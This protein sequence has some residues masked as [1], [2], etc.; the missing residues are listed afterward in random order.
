M[1]SLTVPKLSGGVNAS[2]DPTMIEDNELASAQNVRWKNGTLIKRQAVRAVGTTPFNEIQGDPQLSL[3]GTADSVLS[4][5]MDIGG[6]LCTLVHSGVRY[7]DSLTWESVQVISLGGEVKATYRVMDR[8]VQNAV[9]VPCDPTTYGCPFLM[10]RGCAVFKP[11]E[12]TGTMVAVPDEELYAPLVMIN[13]KSAVNAVAEDASAMANGVMYEGFNLLTRRYRARF[14]TQ[15]GSGCEVFKMPTPLASGTTVSVDIVTSQGELFLQGKVGETVANGS[16]QLCVQPDGAVQMYPC[17]PASLVSDNLTVTATA[18]HTTVSQMEGGAT[19]GVWFGGTQNKLGGTRLFL[20][21]F[22]GEKAKVMWSDVNNPLYFPENNYMFVGDLSQKVTALEKQGDMLVIF[23]EREVYY[24]TY[25]QGEIDADSVANGTNVDVT[26]SQAHF[27][28][29]QLSPYIGCDAPASLAVCRDRLVWICTDGRVY[30]LIEGSPYSERNVREIG[31]KIYPLMSS[32]DKVLLK[33][34]SAMDYDGCYTVLIG[35]TAYSFDYGDSGF[36]A[37]TSYYTA[38]KAAENIAWY[39]HR[40]EVFASYETLRLVS[41]GAH[42]AILISTQTRLQYFTHIRMLYRFEDAEQDSHAAVTLSA[43]LAAL[44]TVITD[45]MITTR[46]TTKTYDFGDISCFKRIVSLFLSADAEELT[47]RFTADGREAVAVHRLCA[48]G[49]GGQLLLPCVKRCRT[50][51][52]TITSE[53]AFGLR[54]MRVQYTTFGT[55]R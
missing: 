51:S 26:V 22:A 49:R 7:G 36:A 3:T 32:H 11:D 46:F 39:V 29:T 38:E 18:A 55:V 2:V 6:E 31:Q 35:N 52:M 45:A 4:H 13:G 8:H 33:N 25:V 48:D 30:T 50:F 42:R 21:G 9:F 12:N 54:G 47:V 27:P 37:V 24:T 15:G 28:L 10:I 17:P 43:D 40:F 5:P 53:T 1:C 19:L 44:N 20:A 14:T 16:Y 23:K 34:A 41:D